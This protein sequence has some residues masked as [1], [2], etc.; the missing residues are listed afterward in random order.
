MDFFSR[1]TKHIKKIRQN[2]FVTILVAIFPIFSIFACDQEENIQVALAFVDKRPLSD[3]AV[4]GSLHV[5]IRRL[6]S[7]VPEVFGTVPV[8]N[9]LQLASEIPTNTPFYI[10]VWG[11]ER[12]D[13][14]APEDV[15]ARGCTGQLVVANGETTRVVEVALHSVGSDLANACPPNL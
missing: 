8:E 2:Y 7:N 3:T 9:G 6:D 12:I 1:H 4:I 5:I 13:R 14:C 11:C 15:V 10:D